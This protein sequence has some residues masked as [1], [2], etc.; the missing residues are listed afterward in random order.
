M[1]IYGCVYLLEEPSWWHTLPCAWG[2]CY[3]ICQDLWQ[4]Y[5]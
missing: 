1:Y 2:W 5:Q 3:S 4:R